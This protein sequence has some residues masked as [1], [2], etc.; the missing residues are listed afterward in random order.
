MTGLV[1]EVDPKNAYSQG[2]SAIM[3][4]IP[5]MSRMPPSMEVM[6][7]TTRCRFAKAHA[8]APVNPRRHATICV[9]PTMR[10]GIHH[11]L[12]PGLRHRLT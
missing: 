8:V 12:N 2:H 4:A 5:E 6:N 7:T 10:Q 11:G 9:G 1:W 3:I